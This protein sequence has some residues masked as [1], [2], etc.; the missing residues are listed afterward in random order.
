[1]VYAVSELLLVMKQLLGLKKINYLCRLLE[2]KT[3]LCHLNQN[4]KPI[5]YHFMVTPT[6]F[7]F[8]HPI[9]IAYQMYVYGVFRQQSSQDLPNKMHGRKLYYASPT[10]FAANL[11]GIKKCTQL[12]LE[13]SSHLLQAEVH[14][15]PAVN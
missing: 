3:T 10:N 2:N 9:T 1:M 8:S 12:V 4:T 6:P 5:R 7:L 13:M 15:S 14:H 11:K